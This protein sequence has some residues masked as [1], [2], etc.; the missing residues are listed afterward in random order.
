MSK[1]KPIYKAIREASR[2]ATDEFAKAMGEIIERDKISPSEMKEM[3]FT[4]NVHTGVISSKDNVHVPV[5]YEVNFG[6]EITQKDY[7]IL[8]AKVAARAGETEVIIKGK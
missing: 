4:Q 5:F 3:C 1:D 8:C 7:E 6:Q 2:R